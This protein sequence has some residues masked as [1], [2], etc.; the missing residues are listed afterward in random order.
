MQFVD[1]ALIRV[2]AGDGGKGAVAFRRE[3][4]VPKGGPAGGDGGNG[5]SVVLVVDGGLSTLLDFRYRKEYQAPAGEGGANKDRYGHAGADLILRV[6]PGTQVFDQGNGKLLADLHADGERFVL[7]RGGHGGRGNIHFAT[8]TDRAPRRFEPGLPGEERSVRLDLKLLADVGLLGF[9]NVGKSSLISRISAARPKIA[10]YPFTTLVPNLGMVRLS[11]ERSFVVA[12][13]PGLIEGA[14][15]GAGLGDRFL[16][17]VERTR[18]LVH[19]VDAT[20]GP[21]RAPLRDYDAINRELALFD[22]RLA[23]RPQL[24][25]LNKVDLPDV[26]RVARRT[27]AQFARRGL[28]LLTISAATGAGLNELLEAIWRVLAREKARVAAAAGAGPG[29]AARSAPPEPP[30]VVAAPVAPRAP[31]SAGAPTMGTPATKPRRAVVRKPASA[32]TRPRAK[33][34]ASK[35][36]PGLAARRRED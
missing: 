9:P 10:D 5:G 28:E 14:H 1:Q 36:R 15:R 23:E 27:A 3:K 34:A 26:S 33:G 11:S 17:H 21:D 13:I 7:A 18:V 19:L 6:P 12:D 8:S 4:F 32:S 25:V 24:V 22:P 30:Q 35:S 29:P 16:R 31:A 2:R 20:A